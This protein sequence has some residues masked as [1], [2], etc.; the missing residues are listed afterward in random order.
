L[1]IRG[2]KVISFIYI[3]LRNGLSYWVGPK[4]AVSRDKKLNFLNIFILF[5]GK[6]TLDL[7][8]RPASQFFEKVSESSQRCSAGQGARWY[9]YFQTK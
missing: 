9:T 3:S 5:S 6:R 1:H 4:E 8:Y 2:Y 7:N